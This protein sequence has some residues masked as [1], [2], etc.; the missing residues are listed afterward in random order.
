MHFA[1]RINRIEPSA[2]LAASAEAEK[3]RQQGVDVVDFGPGEPDFPTP[4]HIKQA[5][6]RAIEQDFSKYTAVGGILPLR[7][8]VVEWHAAQFGSAYEPTESIACTG[9]KH[10]LFNAMHVLLGHGDEVLIPVPYWVTFPDIVRYA[11]ATPVFLSTAAKERFQLRAA[12]VERA[13]TPRT[14]MLIVNSPNN[15]SGAV[16]PADEFG[17]IYEVCRAR[18]IWLLADECYSH[19]TYGDARPYSVA[20]ITGSKPH[21][22]VIGSLSK[23]FAM[24][25]WRLGYALGPR[26]L[27]EAI[28]K[29][30]SQSTSN[31][32]SITQ[33]AAVAALT[34]SMEPCKAMLAEYARRRA[35]VLEGLAAI[36]GVR[37][38]APEGAF[39][40]FP[41]VEKL[42]GPGAGAN[43]LEITHNLL[44]H[45]HV[46]VV[47]GDAF[48]MPGHLRFSYATSMER[49]EEGLRRITRFFKG[50]GAPAAG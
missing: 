12:E 49:I 37:C 35:R 48:G 33:H 45:A 15:P 3:L 8:A 41:N 14:R 46:A 38:A 39:Y 6:I 40:V 42:C 26:P 18:R 50:Q 34:G 32:N 47:A 29:L 19:F 23:T 28:A 24:T 22:I 30:Q 27:I 7:K 20:S 4:E 21:I 17:R 36:S 9:G 44:H 16:I 25:G 2:T 43:T 11:G 31:P 1:D 10:A 13:I 5:A